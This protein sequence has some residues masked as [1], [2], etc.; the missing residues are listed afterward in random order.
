MQISLRSFP[1][2]AC[3]SI[4]VFVSS[5]RLLSNGSLSSTTIS[6]SLLFK[7]ES[8]AQLLTFDRWIPRQSRSMLKMGL[9][10][11]L[12]GSDSNETSECLKTDKKCLQGIRVFWNWRHWHDGRLSSSPMLTVQLF[13]SKTTW[14]SPSLIFFMSSAL[15]A[16]AFFFRFFHML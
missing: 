6:S 3:G 8:Y 13:G 14:Y 1:V 5:P 9:F 12:S 2:I 10:L 4:L 15:K 11:Y 16:I 7:L